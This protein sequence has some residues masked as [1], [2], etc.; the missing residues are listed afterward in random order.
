MNK[1][2]FL[3]KYGLLLVF[4]L[5]LNLFSYYIFV[6]YKAKK[7]YFNLKEEV[8]KTDIGSL[9]NNSAN[10]DI[11]RAEDDNNIHVEMNLQIS[12][13]PLNNQS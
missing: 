3:E 8:E 9:L 7:S 2:N 4:G 12:N 10:Y 6:K 13:N 1:N 5:I 11:N